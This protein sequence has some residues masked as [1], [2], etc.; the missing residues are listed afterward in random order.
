[1]R[2][3][4]SLLAA[5]ATAEATVASIKAAIAAHERIGHDDALLDLGSVEAEGVSR[6]TARSWIRS[7]RLE[8]HQAERGRFVFRRSALLRALES[9][10]VRQREKAAPTDLD[11]WE[12]EANAALRLVGGTR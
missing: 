7:G 10:P 8:A 9:S 6:H 5:L 11:A 1:L 2:D 4:S 12:H 3:L